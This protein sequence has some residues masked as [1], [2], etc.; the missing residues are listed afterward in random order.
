MTLSKNHVPYTAV[1]QAAAPR[2]NRGDRQLHS[3]QRKIEVALSLMI[4]SQEDASAT[5]TVLAAAMLR[6]AWEDINDTRR[7]SYAGNQSYKLDPRND[8]DNP[9]LLSPEEEQKV[10]SGRQKG[11]GKGKGKG[12]Q[13]S[14]QQ[15]QPQQQRSQGVRLAEESRGGVTPETHRNV[16]MK[17]SPIGRANGGTPNARTPP[18]PVPHAKIESNCCS[19]QIQN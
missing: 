10:R 9:R 8:L 2:R 12:W 1:P 5:P 13:Y 19:I 11:K 6:S 7:R 3:L 4:E 15:Q 18:N 16:G 17:G 14:W